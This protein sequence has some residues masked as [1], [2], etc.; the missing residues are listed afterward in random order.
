[1]KNKNESDYLEPRSAA[2]WLRLTSA[3]PLLEGDLRG[4]P[5]WRFGHSCYEPL[6]PSQAARAATY[7]EVSSGSCQGAS[8]SA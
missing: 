5:R 6:S 3:Q 2:Q 4:E 1:M 8:A 7:M